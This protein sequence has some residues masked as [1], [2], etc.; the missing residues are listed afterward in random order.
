MPL[1]APLPAALSGTPE[2]LDTKAA[3]KVLGV[4][5]KGPEAMRARGGGPGYVRIGRRVR[6][7]ASDL[8]R[9]K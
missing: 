4:S 2:Y 7:R 5:A 9:A 6:Y 1:P 3:A 8:P